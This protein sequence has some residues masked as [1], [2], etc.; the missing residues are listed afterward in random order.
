MAL[1]PILL[2]LA[3]L[4]SKPK[5]FKLAKS[6]RFQTEKKKLFVQGDS[7]V[8]E[9]RDAFGTRNSEQKCTSKLFET[10]KKESDKKKKEELK[11]IKAFKPSDKDEL[12][13][14]DGIFRNRETIAGDPVRRNREGSKDSSDSTFSNKWRG[15]PRK[16][17]NDRKIMKVV[18]SKTDAPS[19]KTGV[20][21]QAKV[22]MGI[23]QEVDNDDVNASRLIVADSESGMLFL[24]VKYFLGSFWHCCSFLFLQIL[25]F[26]ADIDG[27]SWA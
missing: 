25:N 18:K 16:I 23:N 14:L 24:C 19:I 3:D 4:S 1:D 12:E 2:D 10:D 26:E 17:G 7:V 20:I 11:T 22:D 6:A 21:Q 9:D 27:K 8:E 15:S 13:E 5:C